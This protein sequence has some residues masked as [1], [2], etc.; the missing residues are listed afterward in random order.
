M[1]VKASH[2]AKEQGLADGY[3][4]VINEGKN[5]QQTVNHIHIHLIGGR[6]MKWPPGWQY[7]I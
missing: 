4:I 3:R 1:L 5:G 7:L 6:Q 2:I